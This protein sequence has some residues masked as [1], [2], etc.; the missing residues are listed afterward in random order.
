M[1]LPNRLVGGIGQFMPE[2]VRNGTI[3]SGW[4]WAAN[5]AKGAIAGDVNAPIAGNEADLTPAQRYVSMKAMGMKPNAAEAT[6]SAPLKGA[7]WLNEDS[8]FAAPTYTKARAENLAALNRFTNEKLV[9]ASPQPTDAGLAT[10]QNS[11][12]RM[13]DANQA[14]HVA[15]VSRILDHASPL[16]PEE[17]GAAIQQGLRNAQTGLQNDAANG[18]SELDKAVG[19]RKLSGMTIQQTAKNIYDANADYFAKHPS[20]VPTQAW[21]LV[22]DLA[23]ADTEFQSRPMSFGEVHQLR[24]DLLEL[25]RTNPD[26]VKNQAGGWLQQLADAADQTMTRSAGGLNPQGT[27]IFRDA[28]EAWAN[29]KGTYDNPSHPF[30]QAVRTPAPSTLV[31]GIG[32]TPEM[33]K[34][35]QSAL[36]PEGI[37]PIQRG[38]AEKLLGTAKEGGYDFKN[39]QANWNKL[40]QPYREALFTPGQISQFE[41]LAN[42]TANN[43]FYD[44]QNVLYKIANARDPSTVLNL[45]KTPEAVDALKSV[46]GPE[47]MGPIQ[48][49]VAENLLRTTKEGGYNFKTFQGQWN[50]LSD[51]YKNK[52]FTPEQIK[53]FD[54]IGNA[55]TVMHEDVNPSG[56]AHM[57]QKMFEMGEAGGTLIPAVTGHPLPLAATIAYHAAQYALGKRM[58]A[59]TFVD[60]LMR[61]QEAAPAAAASTAS[62]MIPAAVMGGTTGPLEQPNYYSDDYLRSKA[63][64]DAAR[65]GSSSQ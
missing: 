57:G 2:A 35:L 65:G 49:G 32:Q 50:K 64:F 18:F 38:V 34:T 48:R 45:V 23:G 27:Q 24:S 46:L 44:P 30:Y 5:K 6:N 58:N 21:K 47:D 7:Q 15:Q 39:F 10:V 20:L 3:A 60:W 42:R 19:N 25:V 26:I 29:M 17:G 1:S 36:G 62:R 9:A 41:D 8:L 54:D 53:E 13:Q 33:A 37:G 52:L 4:D 61:D 11:L 56:S 43:P 12:L 59:P 14:E 31:K 51:A 40:P 28:N 55:G 22:K 63:A 16:G